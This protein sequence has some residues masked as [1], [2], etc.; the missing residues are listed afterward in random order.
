MPA[1]EQQGLIANNPNANV[2]SAYQPFAS[3]GV[4]GGGNWVT[5]RPTAFPVYGRTIGGAR[6]DASARKDALTTFK[7]ELPVLKLPTMRAVRDPYGNAELTSA[8]KGLAPFGTWADRVDWNLTQRL[9][10]ELFHRMDKK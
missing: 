8:D 2:N 9:T 6:G 10:D 4:K 3:V 1:I 5:D 7:I